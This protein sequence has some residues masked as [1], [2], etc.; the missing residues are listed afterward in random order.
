ML[1]QKP[2]R[3]W[4]ALSWIAM[5]VMV[6]I[7]L[8]NLSMLFA[9]HLYYDLHPRLWAMERFMRLWP[10]MTG[11]CI[12]SFAVMGMYKRLWQYAGLNEALRI[13][14]GSLIGVGLTYLYCLATIYVNGGD[15][16]LSAMLPRTTYVIMF[17][18]LAVTTV[19][20][21]FSVRL[22]NQVGVSSR[23]INKSR[24][25]RVMVV[26]AGWGGSQIIRELNARGFRDGMPVVAVDDD[27][28]KTGTRLGSVPIL[29][30]VV[31]IPEYAEQYAVDE[32]IIAIPSANQ[33]LLKEIM[34]ACT[35][36]NCKLK[37]VPGLHDV[38]GG[39]L[40]MGDLRDVN[41]T[42]LLFRD[43]V[44]LDMASIQSYLT[45]R[46]VLVTGGGGSI[47]SELCRQIMVFHPSKLIIFDIYENNAFDL[48]GELK[49]K[50]GDSANVQVLIGSVRDLQRL[51]D[52]FRQ[53]KP[54]V[55]FHA[56]AH[57]HVSLVEQ[58]PAEAI[59]NN[60]FGTMNVARC[61]DKYGVKRMV[62]LSTDK[63]VNPTNI[64]GATKRVT[65]M[66][67]QYMA[68]RSKTRFMAV[69]FGN[70]LGSAGSVLHI[71]MRQIKQ[72]GPVRFM[73]QDITRY[74]MTIPEAAQLVLQAGAIGESGN[75][76][77]LDMGTPVRI[78]DLAKN[79]IRLAGLKPDED[80][81]I[82]VVGLRP[83]EKLYEELMM[84]EEQDTL[85]KT[86]NEKIF[87]L[88]PLE[89]DDQT[90]ERLLSSIK[91]AAEH[92]PELV[93]PILHELVPTFREDET[94][95]AQD[96]DWAG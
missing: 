46:T 68:R 12:G 85:N 70:V 44:K 57:K 81:K 71:F 56:A 79:L 7:V 6:D 93:R 17:M 26:G 47:G 48:R 78:M 94:Q 53:F 33:R 23:R 64:M 76:F 22:V 29:Y 11:L 74:F 37:M 54:D 8:I 13:G 16:G 92:H 63:A 3:S 28:A 84:K 89:L 4:K 43:E 34:D 66:V 31:N 19:L 38:T 61:A 80:I 90:F 77:V 58:S 40:R 49:E 87:V 69:R 14:L 62:T 20:S 82:E 88:Q 39:E 24:R 91:E 86:S 65:E 60:V 45:D 67:I 83:G 52:V 25:K 1:Q 41:I 32:I 36:T 75:V 51:E 59:K 96:K 73:H 5:Q 30:G 10:M 9:L 27:P 18:T 95:Q 42:D 55:V 35:I 21:R 72:G 15:R 2:A 50:Y